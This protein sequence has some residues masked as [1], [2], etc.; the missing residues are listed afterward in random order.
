VY[1]MYP[2]DELGDHGELSDQ[3]SRR[4]GLTRSASTTQ[5][6][7]PTRRPR[8]H[9]TRAVRNARATPANSP[10]S[11]TPAAQAVQEALDRRDNGGEAPAAG[12]Q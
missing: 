7:L 3:A 12:D 11:A 5:A 6:S 4:D 1:D 9:A 8:A 2:W 10:I